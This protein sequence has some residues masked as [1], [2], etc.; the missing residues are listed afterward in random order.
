MREERGITLF[1]ALITLGI[2]T[3]VGVLLLVIMVNTGGLFFKQSGRLEQGL[4]VN[5]ALNNVQESIRVSSGIV[6]SFTSSSSTYTSGS[7]Q[8][9]LKIPSIDSSGNVITNTFDHFVFFLDQ[10]KLRFKV[11]PDAASAR[12]PKDQIF[13]TNTETL[14]FKYFDFQNQEVAPNLANKARVTL[15]LKQKAGADFEQNIATT[16][17]NLRND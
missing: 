15:G 5:D 6:A 17:A 7:D 8:L 13:S 12:S 3:V 9:V 16:E 4:S 14:V 1:E 2:A 10:K 11:F